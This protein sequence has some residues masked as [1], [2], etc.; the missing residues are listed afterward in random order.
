MRYGIDRN[1][2]LL[3]LILL[4]ASAGPL[5]AAPGP[6]VDLTPPDT[7]AATIL[8]G[9]VLDAGEE[10]LLYWDPT[11][12]RC[13]RMGVGGGE[14]WDPLADCLPIEE[15][16]PG[17]NNF[18][19]LRGLDTVTYPPN[20]EVNQS[21]LYSIN[22]DTRR[23]FPLS[24]IGLV[25]DEH[26]G[27]RDF[28][29]SSD[30]QWAVFR[31]NIGGVG[32]TGS[33]GGMLPPPIYKLYV[34]PVDGGAPPH[35][36]WEWQTATGGIY[37][38]G[39]SADS[40]TVFW[41][42]LDADGQVS[43]LSRPIGGG[44]L[45]EYD[46]F[47]ASDSDQTSHFRLAAGGSGVV[48][49]ARETSGSAGFQL[50]ATTA[51]VATATLLS[52]R[53]VADDNF[54]FAE[55]G[56]KIIF[57]SSPTVTQSADELWVVNAFPEIVTDVFD[58]NPTSSN[59]QAD[60]FLLPGLDAAIFRRKI[61]G[62]FGRIEFIR[63]DLGNPSDQQI[64]AS[65]STTSSIAL[66]AFVHGVAGERLIYE[67]QDNTIP[68]DVTIW[69]APLD[70]SSQPLALASGLPEASNFNHVYRNV[71]TPGPGGDY[72]AVA[73]G[74]GDPAVITQYSLTAIHAATG[75]TIDVIEM[76]EDQPRWGVA[77]FAG[78]DFVSDGQRI[79][80][81]SDRDSFPG[82]FKIFSRVLDIDSYQDVVRPFMFLNGPTIVHIESGDAYLEQGAAA[83]D[84]VDGDVTAQIQILGTVD[85]S[86]IGEYPLIYSVTD[87]AGNEAVLQRTVIVTL[88]CDGLPATHVG[89]S[90]N[91]TIIGTSGDDVIVGRGGND[92]LKGKS[93]NDRIC[94]N[95]GRD[96]II[97]GS[98]NDRLF[99]GNQNDTLKPGSGNDAVFGNNGHDK[100][101]GGTGDNSYDGG[102]G[103]DR[104]DHAAS[105]VPVS[106]NLQSGTGTASG[107][108]T[109]ASIEKLIGS[110]FD[111]HLIG[112][113]GTQDL[114]GRDGNDVLEGRGGNDKLFGEDGDDELIGGSGA[115]E[116]VGGAGS[117]ILTGGRG[118]DTLIG[119]I[120]NDSLKGGNG[121]DTLDGGEDDD[122][123]EGGSGND[124]VVGGPGQ[125][126]L[127]GNDGNDVLRGNG[128]DDLLEGGDGNDD[129]A[130]GNGSDQLRPQA[131]NDTADG[132]KGEDTL[133]R[134]SGEDTLI[135]G[136]DV[137]AV[138]YFGMSVGVIVDLG[139]AGAQA[140]NE[141][142]S[143][144]ENVLG[145][146][147][148]DIL[149]GDG[150]ANRLVGAQGRD[151]MFGMG[152]DD[153]LFG[154]DDDD[155]LLGGTGNDELVGGAGVDSAEG[156]AGTD[157]CDAEFE[158]TCEL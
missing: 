82:A 71:A 77:G 27:V 55:D 8:G 96:L 157:T 24:E 120:G 31:Q 9:Y 86:A 142:L 59:T 92:V 146:N 89:T 50:F 137:D 66:Q 87:S 138:S 147:F 38:Y 53:H 124:E 134:L 20:I 37:K 54:D 69:S 49:N 45:T 60:Y 153:A 51:G 47:P 128:G 10:S 56:Q 109:Y 112:A 150:N 73:S 81:R 63:F 130:G 23:R 2:A 11:F 30:N 88:F 125:D 4:V 141:K 7:S 94:G 119:G 95:A 18:Y 133:H 78:F 79:V 19:V 131:G 117:D 41:L 158:T 32:G 135:G 149:V 44:T 5:S 151:R 106:V 25:A 98:G 121:D 108:D 118:I 122:V 48:F 65:V 129:L 104:V 105:A 91:D 103:N 42:G 107:N 84:D 6:I 139:I 36:L 93:G 33:G 101:K 39:I 148:D 116:M 68:N 110:A 152:G 35:E 80:F 154:N 75:E 136:P 3:A 28:E 43:L 67:T 115:D 46:Q 22:I 127:R 76:P 97:G 58:A 64:V 155:E 102:N 90:G 14:L 26:A 85:T 16:M 156:E 12:Q 72:V 34:V 13:T 29:V 57:A 21:H 62:T 123:V 113:V 132:G 17:G 61:T 145:S 144:I 52:S 140:G 74:M 70:G 111:D 114:R 99:G 1:N 83:A 143:E 15:G 126:T 40:S 100:I